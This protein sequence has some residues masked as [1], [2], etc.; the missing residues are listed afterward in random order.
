MFWLALAVFYF[1]LAVLIFS[2]TY[3]EVYP[4]PSPKLRFVL[5]FGSIVN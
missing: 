4:T 5:W 2:D 1:I 3:A